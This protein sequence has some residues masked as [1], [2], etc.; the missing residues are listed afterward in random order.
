MGDNPSYVR[1]K[2]Y[3]FSTVQCTYDELVGANN[4]EPTSPE[5]RKGDLESP[6]GSRVQWSVNP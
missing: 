6:A 3:E 4:P 2:K 1:G 5:E